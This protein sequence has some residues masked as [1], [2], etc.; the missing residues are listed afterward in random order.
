[1]F[2]KIILLYIVSGSNLKYISI[3]KKNNVSVSHNPESN[4]YLSSGIA[5]VN[6]YLNAG[7]N[8]SI[9]TD[10]AASNDGINFFSA[11]KEMWSRL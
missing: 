11:M 6:D 10:G 9:G 4:L 2:C 1:M 7:I 3:M 8:T 5:P